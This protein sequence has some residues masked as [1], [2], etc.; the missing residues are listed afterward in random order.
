MLEEL[1][2]TTEEGD[3]ER[4]AFKHGHVVLTLIKL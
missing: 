4:T 2:I 3:L 1:N